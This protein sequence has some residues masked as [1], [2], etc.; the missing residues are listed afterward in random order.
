MT[1]QAR[2]LIGLSALAAFVGLWDMA[3]FL[4][5]SDADLFPPIVKI[6][7]RAFELGIDREFIGRDL[8]G[9]ISRLTYAALIAIPTAIF[10]GLCAGAFPRVHAAIVPFVNFTLPL[11]KV[12]IFPLM[13]AV[14]GLGDFA[15]VALI[16]IGLFYPL[17]INVLHGTQRLSSGEVFDL[18]RLYEIRGA[19]LWYRVYW[20]GLIAEILVGLKASLGYGFTLVIVSELSASNNGLGNF[21][22]RS[23][24]AF[25]ILDMYAAVFWLCALGWVV[26]ASLD[27]ALERHLRLNPART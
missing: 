3:A 7:G 2:L 10:S 15:K 4:G 25:Q 21:I 20:C 26:Q 19:A 22:W 17:F 11:P 13:L 1:R 9:S 16:S 14:F 6:V 8:W 24:D 5:W 23:W 18:T 27:K 12:A